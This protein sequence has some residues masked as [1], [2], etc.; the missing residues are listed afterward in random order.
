MHVHVWRQ[1]AA[2]CGVTEVA[3]LVELGYLGAAGAD[4]QASQIR[5][6]GAPGAPS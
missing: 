1:E 6:D 3:L 5:T 4:R 2:T